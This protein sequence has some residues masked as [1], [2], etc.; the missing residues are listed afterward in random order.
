[1]QVKK[2]RALILRVLDPCAAV[3]LCF[4]SSATATER[5]AAKPLLQG[6][7]TAAIGSATQCAQ[8]VAVCRAGRLVRLRYVIALQNPLYSG[9]L[10][11]QCCVHLLQ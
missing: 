8:A 9:L 2:R 3:Q 6:R 7:K 1:M 10:L 11:C 4:I 5:W